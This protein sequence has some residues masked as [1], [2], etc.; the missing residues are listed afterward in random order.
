[1]LFNLVFSA[2]GSDNLSTYETFKGISLISSSK[3]YM[4]S[5]DSLG[6]S[7]QSQKDSS[8]ERYNFSE[9]KQFLEARYISFG[10]D[11]SIEQNLEDVVNEFDTL[12]EKSVNK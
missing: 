5:K 2:L 3:N 4:T 6:Q 7:E 1:M 11:E 10:T 12:N 9:V 8:S